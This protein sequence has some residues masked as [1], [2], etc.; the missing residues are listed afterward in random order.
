MVLV[1]KAR[2][3]LP[4]FTSKKPKKLPAH[5][6]YSRL[7]WDDIKDKFL[8]NW[9]EENASSE[10]LP[11]PINIWNKKMREMYEAESSE[12]REYVEK[13][14]NGMASESESEEEDAQL[15]NARQL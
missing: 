4:K 2:K 12:V 8:Q 3:A 15:R 10:P 5:Q 13:H 1:H 9:K 7:Y 6:M 14:R 11:I